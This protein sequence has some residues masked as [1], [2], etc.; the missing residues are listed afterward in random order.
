MCVGTVMCG[1]WR[2]ISLLN[3]MASCVSYALRT[4]WYQLNVVVL[5]CRANVP[6]MMMPWMKLDSWKDLVVVRVA[7]GCWLFVW[8]CVHAWA[9]LFVHHLDCVCLGG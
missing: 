8:M 2:F 1:H 5:S 9:F 3:G 6:D 4:V 7:G